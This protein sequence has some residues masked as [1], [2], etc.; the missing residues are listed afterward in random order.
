MDMEALDEKNPK[1]LFKPVFKMAAG[2]IIADMPFSFRRLVSRF[3][4]TPNINNIWMCIPYTN[5]YLHTLNIYVQRS[6][7]NRD[8]LNCKE[9]TCQVEN[10][11]SGDIH[12]SGT[13]Y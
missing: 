8:W 10:D 3:V 13:H 11:G 2:Y 4:L 12:F 6:R 5:V 1:R 9:V 7:K